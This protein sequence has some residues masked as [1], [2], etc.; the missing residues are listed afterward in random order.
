MKGEEKRKRKGEERGSGRPKKNS[1]AR[2]KGQKKMKRRV[3]HRGR[4]QNYVDNGEWIEIRKIQMK[5]KETKKRAEKGKE[6]LVNIN[7]RC[8]PEG[9]RRELKALSAKRGMGLEMF[10]VEMLRY[11]VDGATTVRAAGEVPSGVTR[12]RPQEDPDL[13]PFSE[14]VEAVVAVEI[15]DGRTVGVK[16]AMVPKSQVVGGGDVLSGGVAKG[17]AAG[18][19]A[20]LEPG[21]TRGGEGSEGTVD[22]FVGAGEVHGQR[23]PQAVEA[24]AE[25]VEPRKAHLAVGAARARYDAEAVAAEERDRIKRYR[26]EKGYPPLPADAGEVESR[27]VLRRRAAQRGE[28][29]PQ[30]GGALTHMAAD[31]DAP[32]KI[33]PDAEIDTSDIPEVTD[34]SRAERG[35]FYRGAE[36]LPDDVDI[37]EATSVE[38][39]Q[40]MSIEEAKRRFPG[41]SVNPTN[42]ERR[43]ILDKL[44][45][46]EMADG[47][48]TMGVDTAL[49]VRSHVISSTNPTPHIVDTAKEATEAALSMR[50]A[51]V[52]KV[53]GEKRMCGFCEKPMERWTATK[54]RCTGCGRNEEI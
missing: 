41:A 25:E 37:R 15:V 27:S 42:E 36:E 51:P 8:V 1:V 12:L 10:C 39:T 17:R 44:A 18:A 45:Q 30:F 31:F 6:R 47:T 19:E 5:R 38:F 24:G 3:I 11:V 43:T 48:Y 49:A 29:A 26:A 23:D 32:M 21:D 54:L 40:E 53:K 35:K 16:T 4:A 22:G 20:R 7:L 52:A 34:W 28:P 46:A 2:G 13:A 33:V 14:Q 50:K 9:L